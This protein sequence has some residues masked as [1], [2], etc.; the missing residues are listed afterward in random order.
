MENVF[1]EHFGKYDVEFNRLLFPVRYKVFIKIPDSDPTILNF[2]IR[3]NGDW[4]P[5]ESEI[6]GGVNELLPAII[7]IIV[8]KENAHSAT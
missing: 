2:N 1:L 7:Q 4:K 5:D 8:S 3:E 6:P